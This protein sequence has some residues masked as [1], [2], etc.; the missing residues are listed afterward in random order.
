MPIHEHGDLDGTPLGRVR[1]VPSMSGERSWGEAVAF[2]R[3]N[4][5][6]ASISGF[7]EFNST[8]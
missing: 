4:R 8:A 1:E 5:P 3:K 2:T 6:R 7:P